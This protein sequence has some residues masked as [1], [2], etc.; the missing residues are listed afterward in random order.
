MERFSQVASEIMQSGLYEHWE[1]EVGVISLK[2]IPT[3]CMYSCRKNT[4]NSFC[5]LQ[6]SMRISKLKKN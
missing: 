4:I 2:T 3:R 6:T 5:R 1:T